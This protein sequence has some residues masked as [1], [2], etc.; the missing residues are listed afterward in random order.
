MA[1]DSADRTAPRRLPLVR[2]PEAEILRDAPT[3]TA[4]PGISAAGPQSEAAAVHA[5]QQSNTAAWMSEI[6]ACD[7]LLRPHRPLATMARSGC[8]RRQTSPRCAACRAARS[9]TRLGGVSCARSSS[10][11]GCGSRPLMSML[12]SRQASSRSPLFQRC[13]R[14]G[15]RARSSLRRRVAFA[16]GFVT[17]REG[18]DEHRAAGA[19]GR[20][21]VAGA[22]A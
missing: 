3:E 22:L 16:L 2:R 1:T 5:K 8:S 20:R 9:T 19:Q 14:L 11:L 18:R 13:H 7:R 21:R 12:G 15:R 10:A 17:T 6:L 4:S